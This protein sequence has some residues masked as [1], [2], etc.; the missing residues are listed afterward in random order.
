M[1]RPE[2]ESQQPT[3]ANIRNTQLLADKNTSW[4]GEKNQTGSENNSHPALPDCRSPELGDHL[5]I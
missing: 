5:F 3:P 4:S 1:A 2:L